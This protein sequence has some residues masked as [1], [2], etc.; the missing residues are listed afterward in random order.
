MTTSAAPPVIAGIN[1]PPAWLTEQT[2]GTLLKEITDALPFGEVKH[3]A[4]TQPQ[5]PPATTVPGGGGTSSQAGGQASTPGGN[6]TVAGNATAPA[7]AAAPPA[8][9][10]PP[11]ADSI[12][13]AASCP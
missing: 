1:P 3:A 8:P 4:P 2:A 9:P 10:G 5:Q 6:Q 12:K 7:P 11:G 13:G